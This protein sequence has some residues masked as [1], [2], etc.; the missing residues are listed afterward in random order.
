MKS[1]SKKIITRIKGG[2]GNQMFRYAAGKALA[3]QRK[4]DLQIDISFLIEHA[5]DTGDHVARKFELML[6]PNITDKV[7]DLEKRHLSLRLRNIRKRLKFLRKPIPLFKEGA[8]N[9]D[10]ALLS[11]TPPAIIDGDFQSE[12][13]FADQQALIR[14][15]FIFPLL[16]VN[17][18][19]NKIVAQIVNSNS[20]SVH[21]RRGDYLHKPIMALNGVC[22]REYYE[23]AI[24][25]MEQQH[26]GA[27]YYFF[28]DDPEWVKNEIVQFAPNHTIIDHN[29]GNNSWKDM[30]LMSLCR[31]NIIANSSFSWWGAWLN[32]NENK[33]V[34][35]PQKWFATTDPYFNTKDL[36]PESWIKL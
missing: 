5:N 36:I 21:V 31:H 26:P 30:Y 9:F 15:S 1:N 24:A 25:L 14:E 28:S 20:V 7:I 22:S 33:I 11:V 3:A 34:I 8:Y 32:R 23:E 18:E 17:D 13:Y 27:S 12:K 4:A 29:T 35:A 16:N 10:A 2:L 6:F 19:N